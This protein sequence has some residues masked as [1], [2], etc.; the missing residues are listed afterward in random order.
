MADYEGECAS[1]SVAYSVATANN[2]NTA[3]YKLE[4]RK[5][6]DTAW[7]EVS[8][9][10][11][12]TLSENIVT[13]AVFSPDSAYDIRVT[14][15]D[16]FAIVTRTAEIPTAFTLLDFN[17]SGRGMAFGKVSEL[18][19]GIEFQLPAYFN[20]AE[21]PSSVKYLDSGQDLN[22]LLTEG[23]YSIPNT[24]VS[25]TLLNKP[26]T[27]TATGSIVVLNE[28]NTNQRLQIAHKGTKG[29]GCIY[30]RC[31]YQGTWGDWQVVHNGGQK[32]LWSGGYYMTATHTITLSEKV[33]E[34][35]SGIMLVFS[36]YSGGTQQNYHWNHFFIS[37]EWVKLHGGTGCSF[38]LT[39]DGAFGIMGSKYL[40]IH[41]DKIGG[42]DVN[43]QTGTAASGIT[44]NNAA[45]ILR[46]VIGV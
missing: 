31:Y 41:D 9:G 23:F 46:Y 29:D 32:V 38:I 8:S 27:S 42:N 22:D 4:K 16:Y 13:G 39:T 30:E 21:T 10:N 28:G 17:A 24:A 1:I 33:S 11:S 19:E 36:R 6:G 35:T 3:T 45:F 40:Y 18:E 26:W 44:Y 15:K 5:N 14:V 2:K 37:K 43:N 20:H 34:Q 25:G 7:E 12:F